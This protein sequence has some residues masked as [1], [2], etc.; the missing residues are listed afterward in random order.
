M[1]GRRTAEGTGRGPS[2]VAYHDQVTN[3]FDFVIVIVLVITVV[4]VALFVILFDTPEVYHKFGPNPVCVVILSHKHDTMYHR[5][6]ILCI[7][8]TLH[9]VSHRFD[10]LFQLTF[11]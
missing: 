4:N 11:K 6:I 3:Q 7:T 10:T 5:N 9:Y 8:E 2:P 1:Q